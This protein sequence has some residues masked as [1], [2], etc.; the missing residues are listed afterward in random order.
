MDLS[1]N[2]GG[3][4]YN[5]TTPDNWAGYASTCGSSHFIMIVCMSLPFF[6][7]FFLRETHGGIFA[8]G[9]EQIGDTKAGSPTTLLIVVNI[10]NFIEETFT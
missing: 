4:F 2:A 7:V 5:Y 1:F 10:N 8:Q 6:V 9:K 3:I